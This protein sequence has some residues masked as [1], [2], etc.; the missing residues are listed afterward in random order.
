MGITKKH[1][2]VRVVGEFVFERPLTSGNRVTASLQ[3]VEFDVK[4]VDESGKPYSMVVPGNL[5]VQWTTNSMAERGL[6]F[7]AY[8]KWRGQSVQI[9][10]TKGE[11]YKTRDGKVKD[12][13]NVV[14]PNGAIGA[15]FGEPTSLEPLDITLIGEHNIG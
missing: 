6:L 1:D 11:Q 7:A 10:L 15:S 12:N 5:S 2:E 14:V 3:N 9:F 13:L 8:K 4:M